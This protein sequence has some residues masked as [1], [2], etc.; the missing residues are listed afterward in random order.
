MFCLTGIDATLEIPRPS[1]GSRPFSPV[2]LVS[3]GV[4]LAG[5]SKD[6][7]VGGAVIAEPSLKCDVEVVVSFRF[8]PFLMR[9]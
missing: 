5:E 6:N 1:I 4:F 8:P 3:V 7:M 2:G 9:G